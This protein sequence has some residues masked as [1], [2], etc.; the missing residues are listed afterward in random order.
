MGLQRVLRCG[1][2][3]F[4]QQEAP[5]PEC[6]WRVRDSG[7]SVDREIEGAKSCFDERSVESNQAFV[8]LV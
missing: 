5:C 7:Y 1:A 2:A 6:L 4:A 8:A 3:L